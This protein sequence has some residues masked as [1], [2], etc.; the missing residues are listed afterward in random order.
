MMIK[1]SQILESYQ[2]QLVEKIEVLLERFHQDLL[3]RKLQPPTVKRHLANTELFLVEYHAFYFLDDISTIRP[4]KIYDFLGVWYFQKIRSPKAKD[5]AEILISLKKFFFFAERQGVLPSTLCGPLKKVCSD[6]SYF[7]R[8]FREYEKNPG[9]FL[10]SHPASSKTSKTSLKEIADRFP[11]Q[12]LDDAILK[13]WSENDAGLTLEEIIDQMMKKYRVF[14]PRDNVILLEPFFRKNQSRRF[15]SQTRHKP[16]PTIH[17]L[18][19]HCMALHRANLVFMRW[20]DRYNCRMGE[21]PAEA[22]TACLDC[23]SLLNCLLA[24][25]NVELISEREIQLGHK[26]LDLMDKMLWK[27]RYTI[28]RALGLELRELSL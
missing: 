7:L 5:L 12:G 21:L 4:E 16:A 11:D 20:L 9:L 15:E 14:E 24:R 18:K 2:S 28:T 27:A 25:L 17:S 8:R 19:E 23:D 26:L 6:K 13:S 10:L 1:A 3:K 22:I